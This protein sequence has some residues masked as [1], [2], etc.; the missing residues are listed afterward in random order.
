MNLK[1]QW[2][3]KIEE[4][5]DVIKNYIDSGQSLSIPNALV[6]IMN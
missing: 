1:F 4:M 2:P 5:G 6:Y 3:P